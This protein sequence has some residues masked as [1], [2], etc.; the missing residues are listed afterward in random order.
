MDPIENQPKKCFIITPIGGDKSDIRRKAEGVINSVIRPVLK[1]LGF[2]DVKA[3][4]EIAITGS[5]NKQV[6]NRIVDDDLVIANL[7]DLNPNVMYELAIRHATM[8]PIVH[9]CE[10]GTD[11]PF[12]IKD[13]RTLFYSDDMFGVK[14][15]EIK[16]EDMISGSLGKEN[17]DNPIYNA[18]QDKIFREV[19]TTG[20]EREFESYLLSR[21]DQLEEKILSNKIIEKNK[22]NKNNQV[23][24]FYST[25]NVELEITNE[26]NL[27]QF[28]VDIREILKNTKDNLEDYNI[29]DKSIDNGDITNIIMVLKFSYVNNIISPV[30]IKNLL[31]SINSDSY[32]VLDVYSTSY[33]DEEI[34][35]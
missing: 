24:K 5:I 35:F 18:I 32:K 27:E 26:F 25:Y 15:L 33:F 13:Q 11:L 31:N 16:L 8:K 34:P 10:I 19:A 21:F 12:D 17:K 22:L 20:T 14:E 28:I 4:H 3:A 23:K 6:I 1:K 30:F 7:T 29:K 2:E 9:I